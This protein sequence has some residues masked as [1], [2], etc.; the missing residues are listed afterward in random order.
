[1]ITIPATNNWAIIMNIVV[2]EGSGPNIP[3]TAKA[4]AIPTVITTVRTF[5]ADVNKPLS[6]GFFRSSLIISAP[7]NN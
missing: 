4:K 3:A 7:F 6:S 1:M 5:V 2:G